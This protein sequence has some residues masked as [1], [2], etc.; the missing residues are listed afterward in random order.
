M[1]SNVTRSRRPSDGIRRRGIR[2]PPVY[3]NSLV[4]EILSYTP[5]TELSPAVANPSGVVISAEIAKLNSVSSGIANR[6]GF[7]PECP[8]DLGQLLLEA[9]VLGRG[10]AGFPAG[11]KL[12][13]TAART[14]L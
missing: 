11:R 9:G 7:I 2:S 13:A 12:A 14:L 10:G 5:Y 1:L 8:R 4:G 6:F 3:S